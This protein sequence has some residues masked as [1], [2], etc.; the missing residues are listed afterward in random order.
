VLYLGDSRVLSDVDPDAVTRVCGCGPGYNAA[1]PSADAAMTRLV[2][3]RLLGELSPRLIVLGVSPWWFSD[4][5]QIKAY[6][7][8]QELLPPW[9]AV[10]SLRPP[11]DISALSVAVGSVWRLYLHRGDV[12]FTL[13]T[14]RSLQV[15]ELRRGFLPR[16]TAGPGAEV[17]SD[18]PTV[19][20]ELFVDF[21]VSGSRYEET[22][23]LVRD[24]AARG[25]Q[26]VLLDLPVHPALGA[27]EQASLAHFTQALT[28]L[29]A[30][31]SV[32]L[33]VPTRS[34]GPGDFSDSLHLGSSGAERLSGDL[35]EALRSSEAALQ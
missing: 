19:R 35:G 12:R 28:D 23:T 10:A 30:A 32:R 24:L 16:P 17:P 34:F 29:A 31:S 7:P 25:T 27:A 14:H 20:R 21:A 13:G 4:A 26:V 33:V 15:Q 6:L 3:E 18:M 8:A 22:R 5:A 2:A 11:D 9:Q 1:F